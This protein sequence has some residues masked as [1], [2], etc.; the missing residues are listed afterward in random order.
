MGKRQD[1][2]IDRQRTPMYHRSEKYILRIH[3]CKIIIYTWNSW[4]N[5]RF[6]VNETLP[7]YKILNQIRYSPIATKC[8]FYVLMIQ[9]SSSLFQWPNV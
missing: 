2:N 3:I 8:L 7:R 5:K 1:V 9:E 6:W 4:I